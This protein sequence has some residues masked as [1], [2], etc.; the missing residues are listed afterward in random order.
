MEQQVEIFKTVPGLEDYQVSNHGRVI[1]NK[2]PN[3]KFLKPQKDA[4]GYYH[5]RLFPQDHS[6]GSYEGS[7]GKKPKLFKVHRLVAET[8]LDRLDTGE[9]LEVNH[10]NGD[11]FD[12]HV[13]NLEWVTRSYNMLHSWKLGLR[14]DAAFK[15][16]PKRHKHLYA[17]FPDGTTKYYRS[18]VQAA[19]LLNSYP[20]CIIRVIRTGVPTNRGKLKGVMFFNLDTL[21]E[22]CKWEVLENERQA[23]MAFNDRLYKDRKRYGAIYRNQRKQNKSCLKEK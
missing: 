16:A 3:P 20:P 22:K 13:D 17:V 5:V 4:I 18:R 6:L 21:P 12:N 11:K 23:I 10:K 19:I 14:Q 8:F 2:G 15:A 9:I 7:R 1:S